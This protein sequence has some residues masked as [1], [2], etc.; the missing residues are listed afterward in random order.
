[1]LLVSSIICDPKSPYT[2][3]DRL[4]KELLQTFFREFVELFFPEQYFY[5]DFSHLNFLSQELFTD[6]LKGE[7]RKVDILAE[8]KLKGAKVLILIHIEPQSYFQKEFHER[9]FIYFSRLYEKY[10]KPILPIAI[11]SYN[12][13]REVPEQLT[14]EIPTFKMVDFHYLQIH[15]IKMEWRTFLCSNNPVAA[16]LISKMGYLQKERIQ[17]KLEFLRMISRLELDPA[18]IELL[19]GFFE[20]YLQLNEEEEIR[21]QEEITKLPKEES[22]AI[23]KLPNSYLEKGVKLGIEQGIEKVVREMYKKGLSEELILEVSKLP[24]EKLREIK[25]Q[26]DEFS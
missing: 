6:I 19:Y 26:M 18:K 11:F 1:M 2:D 25:L 10:R 15:L 4:F 17:V 22:K 5:I 12:D 7:K 14:I 23:L 21:M 8:T 24:I 9:M 20:T 16:A 13:K 3:H